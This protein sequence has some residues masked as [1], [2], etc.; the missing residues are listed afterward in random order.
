MLDFFDTIA[1]YHNR[2]VIDTEMTWVMFYY[3]IAHYWQALGRDAD[4]FENLFS[5]VEYYKNLRSLYPKLTAFGQKER[6][7]PREE[8]YFS[9]D[10]IRAFLLEEIKQCSPNK[11]VWS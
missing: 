8:G 3:W 2:Q 5:G 7:L 4:Y 6:K 10:S 1:L 9:E 11:P